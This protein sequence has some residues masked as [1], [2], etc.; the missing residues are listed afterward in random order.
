MTMKMIMTRAELILAMTKVEEEAKVVERSEKRQIRT[1]QFFRKPK[2]DRFDFS[3]F[4]LSK[5][6]YCR[7]SGIP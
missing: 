6:V 2:L 1:G 7:Q 5:L 4:Y 3:K